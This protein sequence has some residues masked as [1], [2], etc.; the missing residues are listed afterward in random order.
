MKQSAPTPPPNSDALDDDFIQALTSAQADVPA[1]PGLVDRVRQRIMKRIAQDSTPR[2]LSV[3]A[4]EDG[5]HALRP[6]IERKVLHVSHEG[7]VSCL[8]R[9]APGATVPAHRHPVDEECVVLQGSLRIG[10]DLVLDTGSFHMGRKHVAHAAITSDDGAVIF[11][12]GAEPSDELL[13]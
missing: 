1:P 7:I 3:P 12:R 6:G 8:M 11:V 4:D 5:W 13:I 2:H 10:T 9:L